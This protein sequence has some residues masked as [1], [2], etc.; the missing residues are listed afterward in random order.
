[1]KQL[2]AGFIL[3]LLAACAAGGDEPAC[4]STGFVR[5]AATYPVI[6]TEAKQMAAGDLAARGVL[7]RI[8]GSCKY[9]GENEVALDLTLT[10]AANRGAKGPGLE[11]QQL[12]YFIAVLSPDDEILQRQEFSTKVAFN[13][14]GIATGSEEH[15]IRIPLKDRMAAPTYKVAVGFRL[16]PRQADYNRQ[17]HEN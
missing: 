15:R 4:P 6:A 11:A 3:L 10:F 14:A 8:T 1:M 9:K 13:D 2:F 16:T 12:P 5:G 7:G 17:N